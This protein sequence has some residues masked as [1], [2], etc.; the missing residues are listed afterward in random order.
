[1][2]NLGESD[3]IVDRQVPEP[4]QV[5]P[6]FRRPYVKIVSAVIKQRNELQPNCYMGCE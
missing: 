5:T 2:G 6:A 3:Y 4:V 1:M